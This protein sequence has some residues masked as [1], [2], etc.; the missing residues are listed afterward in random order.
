MHRLSACRL[1]G[2]EDDKGEGKG[3][4]ASAIAVIE[5]WLTETAGWL[6]EAGR[7]EEELFER[8]LAD[9]G[10]VTVECRRSRA[11]D[12]R[13]DEY[14]LRESDGTAQRRT[15]FRISSDGTA[16]EV[17]V[18]LF[19]ACEPDEPTAGRRLAKELYCPG[20]V[21]L[22]IEEREWLLGEMPLPARPLRFATERDGVRLAR[23]V[24]HPTRQ[25]PLI[26]VSLL[27]GHGPSEGFA[28]ELASELA[29]VAAVMEVEEAAT[30]GLTQTLGK[31]WSCFGG[32]VRLFWP[33]PTDEHPLR[34]PLWIAARPGEGDYERE[35][36]VRALHAR[37]VRQTMYG[38][39]AAF[40]ES[41]LLAEV[42]AR[43]R[44]ARLER[45]VKSREETWA[46]LWHELARENAGLRHALADRDNE[47]AELRLI[48]T[49]ND[50]F[51]SGDASTSVGHEPR[52]ADRP[53][54]TR[55]H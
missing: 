53:K 3:P 5:R 54:A 48:A 45:F 10:A 32:A 6:P 22:L 9:G 52:S 28:A 21:R 38:A 7:P 30:W 12:C 13:L 41:R 42:R 34:H 15:V 8:F 44:E 24:E 47:L 18:E 17:Y 36:A 11:D 51:V 23:I 27:D 16:T 14:L 20:A 1:T 29:G 37:L 19:A 46:A 25:L 50:E 2:R 40:A 31:H 4:R 35:R 26:L 33:R 43:V 49:V 39:S 55:A